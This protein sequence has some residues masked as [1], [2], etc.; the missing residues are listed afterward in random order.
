MVRVELHV[1]DISLVRMNL[2]RLNTAVLKV[3]WIVMDVTNLAATNFII[4][5]LY[6][7]QNWLPN[8]RIILVTIRSIIV[9]INI[10]LKILY[11]SLY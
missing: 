9:I 3:R 8:I 5:N 1:A 11:I 4:L 7:I 10:S 6:K 2:H